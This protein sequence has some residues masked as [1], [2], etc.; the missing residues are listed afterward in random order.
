MAAGDRPGS[1]VVTSASGWR[2]TVDEGSPADTLAVALA[3]AARLD[4]RDVETQ[5]TDD[6]HWMTFERTGLIGET[7]GLQLVRRL[8]TRVYRC[9]ALVARRDE[10]RAALAAC[11]TLRR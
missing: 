9:E 8:G 11:K 2:L 5:E 4:A 3:A 1:L 10:A 6:G 7:H